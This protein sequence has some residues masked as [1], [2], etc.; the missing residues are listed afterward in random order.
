VDKLNELGN[1][2]NPFTR[3]QNMTFMAQFSGDQI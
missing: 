3:Y 1:H 2:Y